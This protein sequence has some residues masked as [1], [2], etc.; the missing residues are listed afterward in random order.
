MQPSIV[1]SSPSI[2]LY[3][4]TQNRGAYRL[5]KNKKTTYNLNRFTGCVIWL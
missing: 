1:G 4:G 3:A 5:R 2:T